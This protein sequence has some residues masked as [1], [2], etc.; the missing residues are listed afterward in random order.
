MSNPLAPKG[1]ND[2]VMTP[3]DLAECLVAHFRPHGVICEPC[4]GTGNFLR[5]FPKSA[6]V[7]GFEINDELR[8]SRSHGSD[9]LAHNLSVGESRYDWTFGNPP[10]S[11]FRP[12]LLKSMEVSNNIVFLC[13]I[14]AWFMRARQRDILGHGFG[15]VEIMEITS[16]PKKPWPQAGF[17]LGAAWL[18]RGWTGSTHFSKAAE[19]L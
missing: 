13:L 7:I 3:P 17:C 10:W 5:A 16:V 15:L 6:T 19:G 9:F 11:Q 14:N 8:M 2:N 1:G 12:F 4:Y 18:R